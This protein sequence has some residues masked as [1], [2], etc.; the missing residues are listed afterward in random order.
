MLRTLLN[1]LGLFGLSEPLVS[2]SGADEIPE[3][4]AL[5]QD[6][7]QSALQRLYF[8]TAPKLFAIALR[9]VKRQELAEDVMQEAFV[10]IWR[11][12]RDYSPAKGSVWGWIATIVRNGAIDC[13]RRD[14]EILVDPEETLWERP[15]PADGPLGAFLRREEA[16]GIK[17]CLDQL[18]KDQRQAI[19][20]AYYEGYTHDIVA[21]RLGA[22]LGTIKTW[23]RRGLLRI[24]ECLQS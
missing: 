17:R 10:R 14:R 11:N 21:K 23:I 7:N 15:D 3:L 2:V 1:T 22:P 6:G 18:P 5:I 24:K 9:I 8:L 20:V 16:T 13:V 19:L 4:M 12:C